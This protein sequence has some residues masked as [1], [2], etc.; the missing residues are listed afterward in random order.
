[1]TNSCCR[2]RILTRWN[3]ARFMVIES[4]SIFMTF[5]WKKAWTLLANVS[6]KSKSRTGGWPDIDGGDKLLCRPLC[7]GRSWASKNMWW[8]PWSSPSALSCVWWVLFST[9]WPP[10][11]ILPARCPIRAVSQ[12]WRELAIR[13]IPVP[14][15]EWLLAQHPRRRGRHCRPF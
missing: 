6:C 5:V 8:R 3:V 15:L 1:M 13:F 4:S 9:L 7:R 11:W 2:R 14:Y 12:F 10:S